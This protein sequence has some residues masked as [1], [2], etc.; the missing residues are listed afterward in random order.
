MVFVFPLPKVV[1]FPSTTQPLNIFEPR[2]IEMINDA[3]EKEVEVALACTEAPGEESSG[4]G[5]MG[6]I[7]NIA[8]CGPVQLLERRPD[9]T[10]LILLKSVRKVKLESAV[11]SEKPYILAEEITID[12]QSELDSGNIFYLH[13]ILRELS[14]WLERNVPHPKRREEFIENMKTDEERINTSCSLLIEDSAWQQKLLE[15]N[16][17]NERLKALAALLETGAASH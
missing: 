11:E 5:V 8:G 17:I 10:M 16:D 6:H 15:M 13:R 14:G 1:L 12:E 3:V 4:Q 2:Y 9:G 7:R